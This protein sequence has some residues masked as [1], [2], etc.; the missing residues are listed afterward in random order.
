MPF[1][2]C[3]RECPTFSAAGVSSSPQTQCRT[4][5][6]LWPANVLFAELSPATTYSPLLSGLS[7]TPYFAGSNFAQPSPYLLLHISCLC[8]CFTTRWARVTLRLLHSSRAW[9][10]VLDS[11]IAFDNKRL[12]RWNPPTT[13]LGSYPLLVINPRRNVSNVNVPAGCGVKDA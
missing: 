3:F 13:E 4:Y 8:I 1:S 6:W 2:N 9:R 11:G 10:N 7:V 12:M 5:S